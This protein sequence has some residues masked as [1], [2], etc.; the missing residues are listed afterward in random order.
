MII[1]KIPQS[2]IDEANKSRVLDVIRYYSFKE[3]SVDLDKINPTTLLHRFGIKISLA[4][5]KI[6]V[7]ELISEGKVEVV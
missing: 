2:E 7:Q 3:G 4:D 1:Y 5:A 6:F